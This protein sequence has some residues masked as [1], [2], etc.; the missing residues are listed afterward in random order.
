[1]QVWLAVAPSVTVP[2]LRG[3][4]RVAANSA[5]T[6]A[7]LRL[8]EIGERASDRTAGTIVDQTPAPGSAVRPGTSVQVWLAVL[9][10]ADRSRRA[11]RDRADAAAVPTAARL[12]LGEVRER[13]SD[14][15]VGTV[16]EQSPAPGT[17]VRPDTVVQVWLAV[18]P[19]STVPDLRGRDRA[20][21]A[22]A[23][24]AAHLRLVEAGERQSDRV[25]GTVV[26]QAPAPGTSAP[27]GTDVQVWLAVPI[28]IEVPDLAGRTRAEAERLIA[29]QGTHIRAAIDERSTNTAG[30]VLRQVP[31][32][33]ARVSPGSGIDLVLALAI[34]PSQPVLRIRISWAAPKR[35]RVPYFRPSGSPF[36]PSRRSVRER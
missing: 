20:S 27:A 33:G 3:R 14:R 30:T 24:T 7:R 25:V 4:D 19:P 29:E 18:P 12:R 5:L 9:G 10:A 2:D 28:T 36:G 21:A 17:A 32:A 16:V 1:M 34:V 15:A 11:G 26:D 31:L 35:R 8:G 23:L 13:Q 6:T 22:D